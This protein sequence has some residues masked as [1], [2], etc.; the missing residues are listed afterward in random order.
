MLEKLFKK[1]GFV[2]QTTYNNLLNQ[3][4][5]N[6]KKIAKLEQ[7]NKHLL[8]E[9]NS[10][11]RFKDSLFENI[12]DLA[13]RNTE[14]VI[15]TSTQKNEIKELCGLNQQKR[16]RLRLAEKDKRRLHRI[17]NDLRQQIDVMQTKDDKTN[18]EF[19]KLKAQ[20]NFTLGMHAILQNNYDR[21]A[22]LIYLPEC[23]RLKLLAQYQRTYLDSV[24]NQYV[25][26]LLQQ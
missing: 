23:I 1:F 14:L 17:I 10:L 3:Q 4:E 26:S 22:H 24:E 15:K 7:Q 18:Q 6:T 2:S 11:N 21:V 13:Q 12:S 20:L 25:R 19:K 8:E 5:E 16:N 9:Y